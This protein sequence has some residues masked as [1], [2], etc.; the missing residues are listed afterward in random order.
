[1]NYD[2]DFL[3]DNK[4]PTHYLTLALHQGVW[5]SIKTGKAKCIP[6]LHSFDRCQKV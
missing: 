4:T 3:S 2:N 5:H 6:S 1:M